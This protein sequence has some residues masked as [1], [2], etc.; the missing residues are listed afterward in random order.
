MIAIALVLAASDVASAELAM[1]RCFYGQG[2][3]L[4]DHI[5]SAAVVAQ[6]VVSACGSEVTDWK[7]D[8]QAQMTPPDLGIFY[9]HVDD[10]AQSKATEVVL[11]LRAA[12]RETQKAPK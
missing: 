4:D 8:L 1:M 12:R 11:R 9:R 3:E 7:F 10:A 6:G 2:Y 5:S